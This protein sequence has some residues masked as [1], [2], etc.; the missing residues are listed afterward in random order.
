MEDFYK[1]KICNFPKGSI[2]D[3]N[4]KIQIF[5]YLFLPKIILKIEF[6]H[7]LNE[8]KTFFHFFGKFPIF[9]RF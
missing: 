1:A 8:K 2:Y 3:F 5:L 7:V 4:P 6:L 9:Q